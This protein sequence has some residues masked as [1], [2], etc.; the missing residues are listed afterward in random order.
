MVCNK[1]LD[2]FRPDVLLCAFVAST[3]DTTRF[4]AGRRRWRKKTWFPSKLINVMTEIVKCIELPAESMKRKT[5]STLWPSVTRSVP[6]GGW[7]R[8][9]GRNNVFYRFRIANVESQRCIEMEPIN[10]IHNRNRPRVTRIRCGT[11]YFTVFELWSVQSPWKSKID[12]WTMPAS[13]ATAMKRKRVAF[14]IIKICNLFGPVF[15]SIGR[16]T[17]GFVDRI[18]FTITTWLSRRGD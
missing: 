2:S 18:K 10:P 6:T 1:V 9:A 15:D 17:F 8:C 16:Y 7:Q 12:N 3:S 13:A 11:G 5:L 14:F 4:T